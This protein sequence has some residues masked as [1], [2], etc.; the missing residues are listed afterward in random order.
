MWSETPLSYLVAWK[1]FP[2]PSLKRERNVWIFFPIPASPIRGNSVAIQTLFFL[3]VLLLVHRVL[4]RLV[5]LSTFLI[6]MCS[7]ERKK[8][9]ENSRAASRIRWMHSTRAHLHFD[10][11]GYSINHAR[12]KV[13][14]GVFDFTV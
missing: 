9:S 4:S 7:H 12:G 1:S 6:S 11:N 2:D 8:K 14:K 10:T 3:L 13:S 5:S